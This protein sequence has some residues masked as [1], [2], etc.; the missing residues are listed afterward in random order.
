MNI[1][2][3]G[4]HKENIMKKAKLLDLNKFIDVFEKGILHTARCSLKG[5]NCK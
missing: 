5:E 3:K 2:E 4:E 1:P